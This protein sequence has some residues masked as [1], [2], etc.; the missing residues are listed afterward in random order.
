[1][2]IL[3]DTFVFLA[4][5]CKHETPV[6]L[7]THGTCVCIFFTAGDKRKKVECGMKNLKRDDLFHLTRIF[8]FH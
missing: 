6:F 8:S 4:K 1:M 3:L 2:T 7:K 5:V